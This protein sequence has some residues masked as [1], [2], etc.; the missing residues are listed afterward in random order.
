MKKEDF[1][2]NVLNSVD[3]I[4]KAIPQDDLFSKIEQKIATKNV[5]PMQTIWLV[6]ASI[7]VLISL[8]VVLLNGSTT[9][10]KSEIAGLESVIN[11]NN[12][13]YK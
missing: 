11:K 6:A 10:N 8:N 2:N 4:S 12:Q 13:L 7:V 5:V 1:I 3:G 9:S